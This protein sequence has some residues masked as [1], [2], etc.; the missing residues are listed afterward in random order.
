MVV[1]STR[2]YIQLNCSYQIYHYCTR[3]AAL[4]TR[5]LVGFMRQGPRWYLDVVSDYIQRA[6]H[7]LLTISLSISA[8]YPVPL[9]EMAT[10]FELPLLRLTCT[11]LEPGVCPSEVGKKATV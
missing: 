11:T 8:T 10:V 9:L 6:G 1:G 2:I 4:S 5:Q 3:L 7:V